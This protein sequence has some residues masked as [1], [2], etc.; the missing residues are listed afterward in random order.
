MKVII[1]YEYL[2]EYNHRYFAK[3]WIDKAYFSECSDKSF[4]EAKD[5]LIKALIK[6]S[7]TP[8]VVPP[9]PE[10]VEIEVGEAIHANQS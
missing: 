8:P 6:F 1:N 4:E 2:P 9:M 10:V 3:T 5:K 7:N